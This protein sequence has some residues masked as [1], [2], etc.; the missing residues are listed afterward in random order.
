MQHP[1]VQRRGGEEHPQLHNPNLLSG[2]HPGRQRPD[3]PSV[4][5]L[6]G[7]G[8]GELGVEVGGPHEEHGLV[9]GGALLGGVDQLEG[10]EEDVLLRGDGAGEVVA[11]GEEGV[12]P[13][14]EGESGGG[15]G[16]EEVGPLQVGFSV[17]EVVG[18]GKQ[19]VGQAEAGADLG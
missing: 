4:I 16:Q 2:L 3:R 15:A 1:H 10:L 9:L 11:V 13:E 8:G 12:G 18:V 14:L 7:K 5:P 17:G 6:D 19:E